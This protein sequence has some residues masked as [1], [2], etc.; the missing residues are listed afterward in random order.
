MF[1]AF[2]KAGDPIEFT[3]NHLPKCPHCGKYA[4]HETEHERQYQSE[5]RHCGQSFE[6]T[7]K[8][9]IMYDTV[10]KICNDET[11]ESE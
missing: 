11:E 8:L 7:A 4:G 9:V 10:P 3:C 1:E 2:N 5:C 6:V